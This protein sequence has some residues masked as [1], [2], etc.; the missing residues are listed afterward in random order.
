MNIKAAQ[1]FAA[2]SLVWNGLTGGNTEDQLS[3][4]AM[5]EHGYGLIYYENTVWQ[6]F[7]DN[8]LAGMFHKLQELQKNNIRPICVAVKKEW[9]KPMPVAVGR[10]LL[11]QLIQD[12]TAKNFYQQMQLQCI[13][14]IEL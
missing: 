6:M 14:T 12:K 1:G 3:P 13:E 10:K 9:R 8:R 7:F 2:F 11:L 5:K 4:V